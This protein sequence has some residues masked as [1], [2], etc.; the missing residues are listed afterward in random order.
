MWS[1]Q[2][3][4]PVR[5]FE[6]RF[7]G[8]TDFRSI[9]FMRMFL[10]GFD[11]EVTMRFARLELVRGEWRTFQGNLVE[12]GEIDQNDNGETEFVVGAVNIEE[13]STR[14]PIPYVEPP[15]IVREIDVGSANLRSLNEQSLSLTVCN[16]EDGD[17]RA[18]YRNVNFDMRMYERLKMFV[19]AEHVEGFNN[20]IEKGDLT[21]FLRLGSDFDDNYYEYEIPLTPTP[22]NSGVDSEIW[23]EANN[24]DIELAVLQA[25][26]RERDLAPG[27]STLVEYESSSA[28]ANTRI[29]IKGNPN[30]A[31]VVTVMVGLRNPKQGDNQFAPDDG[32]SE[33]AVVWI[34]ELRLTDFNNQGGGAAIATLNTTL[35][36]FGNIAVASSISNP[37]FGTLEQTLQE[38]QR[39]TRKSFDAQSTLQ[40]GKLFGEKLGVQLPVYVGYSVNTMDP[41]FD[42]LS[43]DLL[44]TDVYNDLRSQENADSLL[45]AKQNKVQTRTTRRTIN[46]SNIRISP[47]SSGGDKKDGGDKGGKDSGGKGKGGGKS[48]GKKQ[49]PFYSVKNFSLNY[50]YSDID[51]TDIN[52]EEDLTISERAGLNYSFSYKPVEIKPFSNIGFI[53]NT[54]ALK[55][56][57]DFNF[58]L[59]PKQI[60]FTTSTDRTYRQTK[61]RDNSFDLLGL[62]S[63]IEIDP[64]VMK[65]WNW[66]RNYIFKYD[67]TKSLK[68]DFQ[69]SNESLI[70]E[71]QGVRADLAAE[72]YQNSLR[73]L[74]VIPQDSVGAGFLP[75]VTSGYNHNLNL[76]YKVPFDKFPLINFITGDARYAA[77]YRWTRAPLA[78]LDLGNTIQ[79]TRNITLNAQANFSKLYNKSKYL[80][81]L[82]RGKVPKKKEKEKDDEEPKEEEGDVDGF[83]DK[84]DDPKKKKKKGPKFTP[85]HRALQLAM[86]LKSV[87]GNY[88]RNEGML[89]PGYNQNSYLFGMSQGFSGPGLDFITGQQNASL[90][91][92]NDEGILEL[93]SDNGWLGNNP[94]L[95]IQQ[96][97]T[98]SE[99]YSFRA[100][101]E[102]IKDVKIELTMNSQYSENASAFYVFQTPTAENGVI[103]D[104]DLAAFDMFDEPGD[105]V[106]LSPNITG[107]YTASIISW[108][109]A[110]VKDRDEGEGADNG[111]EIWDAFLDDY[112]QIISERVANFYHD[113]DGTNI[114]NNP[115]IQS[116]NPEFAGFYE[117]YGPLSQRVAIPAFVAAYTGQPVDK[118]SLNPFKQKVAPNWSLRYNGLTKIKSMKKIFKQFRINHSYKSNYTTSFVTNVG[119]GGPVEG[120]PG[121]F[122]TVEDVDQSPFENYQNQRQISTVS[123]VEQLSPLIGFDMTL[124]KKN[125]NKKPIDPQ[126]KIE[127]RRDRTITLGLSNFQ[128]TE[129]KSKALVIGIGGK[130]PDVPIG[131]L[132]NKRSRL[133]GKYLE[134]SPITLRADLTIRDNVTLIRR[135]EERLNQATAG[136][137][138]FSLKTSAD[139]QISTQLTLRFFYDHQITKPKIS[140]SFPTSNV[141]SGISLRF[142]LSQ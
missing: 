38:R 15:G 60:G 41:Q 63:G 55:F 86:M 1:Y 139:L 42:P 129:T 72:D 25:L 34:N 80:K 130:I 114:Y 53:K 29:R 79:N 73:E 105:F 20:P 61:I 88:S 74:N 99:S 138:L 110:F 24:F 127:I 46:F 97:S 65:N 36:D 45:L 35:A 22:H 27:V 39:E 100:N 4:I 124:N 7:N 131:W 90:F 14:S 33:C 23:P 76:S 2:F 12:G 32:Q 119:Y 87:S 16:L 11:E 135:I 52:T 98:F 93:I 94:L 37:G 125:K 104:P 134:N 116:A 66:T 103:P 69:A 31:N 47:Q 18:A 113:A 19:H 30:L 83:G 115:L 84:V 49:T 95:N 122:N 40:L 5:D 10:K 137:R 3:K 50:N 117:G 109:T 54:P 133:P 141:S 26:K 9:R 13:N 6:K 28:P 8:I 101:I 136:Q 64:Q 89:I 71:P 118:V 82:N 57:K 112:R 102:P 107:N 91:G 142:Q 75:G 108:P 111:N 59:G 121:T 77:T 44:L 123:I 43:P 68:L 21:C 132:R 106:P 128:I 140:T 96:S 56:I 85:V 70:R 58:N 78:Q 67:F 48:G 126:I 81:D 17:S 62:E 51:F 120:N 92:N